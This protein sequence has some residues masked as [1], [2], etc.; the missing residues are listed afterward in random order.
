[1]V[2]NV[3][4]LVTLPTLEGTYTRAR[5]VGFHV[6]WGW[7]RTVSKVVFLLRKEDI[8]DV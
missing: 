1:M 6:D 2:G 7:V 4:G 5:P 8:L 3:G